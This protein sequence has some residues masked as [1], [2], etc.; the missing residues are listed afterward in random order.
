MAT[1]S[2]TAYSPGIAGNFFFFNKQLHFAL[3]RGVGPRGKWRATGLRD[4]KRCEPDGCCQKRTVLGNY[5]MIQAGILISL[6]FGVQLGGQV[7]L[8]MTTQTRFV[9]RRYRKQIGAH[10]ILQQCPR[11]K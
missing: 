4:G 6:E 8:G 1:S 5:V 3:G 10:S 7:Q 11:A 9:R 2:S